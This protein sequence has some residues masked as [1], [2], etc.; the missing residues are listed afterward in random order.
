MLTDK[1]YEQ[2][3]EMRAQVLELNDLKEEA[4][5]RGIHFQKQI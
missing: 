2:I 3:Q 5:Q 4:E 1:L